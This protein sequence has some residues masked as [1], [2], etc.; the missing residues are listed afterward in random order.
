M[1]LRRGRERIF[2]TTPKHK[3]VIIDLYSLEL[4]VTK[5]VNLEQV[6]LD[7]ILE[8]T[9]ASVFALDCW[10]HFG[11]LYQKLW[12]LFQYIMENIFM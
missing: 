3:V 12:E 9:T 10:Y 2:S 5:A 7:W 11:I 1:S 6:A 8:T 4:F